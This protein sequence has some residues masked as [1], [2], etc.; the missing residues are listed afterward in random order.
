MALIQDYFLKTENYIKEYGENTLVFIQVGS[1]YEVY[2]KKSQD[3]IIG[4]KIELFALYCDLNIV[5][6]NVCVGEKQIVM[7]GF[8]DFLIDK[9]VK[10]VLDKGFTVIE[11][12]QDAP[13]KNTTRSVRN[14]YS[15]GSYF[16]TQ[17]TENISNHSICIWIYKINKMI[18]IGLVCIDIFTGISSLFEFQ[19]IYYASPTTFDELERYISIYNPSE[20]IFIHNLSSQEI[21]NIIQFIHLK[22]KTNHIISLEDDKESINYKK[23]INC[24]KQI[25]QKEILMKFFPIQDFSSF[26]EPYTHVIFAT[27]AFCF[28]LDFLFLH[29][30]HLVYKIQEP[31]FEN[32]NQRLILANHSLKQLNILEDDN[33]K[34]KYSCMLNL[35]NNCKTNMGKRKFNN[36]FLNPLN[37]VDKLNS[38]YNLLESLLKLNNEEEYS[39]IQLQLTKMKDLEKINRQIL[40]QKIPPKTFYMIYENSFI[41]QEIIEKVEK[42]KILW[43]YLQ[44]LP[45]FHLLKE[46]IVQITDYIKSNLNINIISTCDQYSSFDTNFILQNIDEDLDNETRIIE[47]SYDKLNVCKMY[48]HDLLANYEKSKKETEYIKIH[49]TEKNNYSLSITN[50][51]SKI[52]KDLLKNKKVELS[53]L[54]SY[55]KIQKEFVLDLEKFPLEFHKQTSTNQFIYHVQINELCKNIHYLKNKIKEHIQRVYS[56]FIKKFGPFYKSLECLIHFITQIDILWCHMYNIQKFHLTKPTIESSDQSFFKISNIRHLLIEHFQTEEIYVANDLDLGTSTQQGMLLYGTNAVGKTSLIKSIG[57]AILMAQSGMF[58]PCTNMIYCPYKSIFTRIIG[59][60]NLFKGLS[61]FAVEMSEL[62]TILRMADKNSLILGD[63]LCSGTESVSAI[64]IFLAGIKQ[65]YDKKSSFIFA[66]HYHEII[67]MEEITSLENLS[68]NHMEVFYDKEKE[69][70]IY[71]R[72]VKKGPG[73]NMYGLEVCKSLLLP[74]DFLELANNIRLKYHPES[75][76][77]LLKKTSQYNSQKIKNLCENCGLHPCDEVHHLEHQQTANKKGVIKTD[78]NIFHKNHLANLMNLCKS[79]HDNIHKNKKKIKK[80]KGNIFITS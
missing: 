20:T 15:P 78:Q 65:L 47:E 19:E 61:T 34:G 22:S 37:D 36:I 10:K 56:Q 68:L 58:V 17:N 67:Q 16:F 71:D 53:Y 24:E 70:L 18:Y 9:Y 38:Q 32:N 66:T 13:E 49:E 25:Y 14:I 5:E 80:V 60:D 44:F 54:S 50:R 57:I 74:Q 31:I 73:N 29:N 1:F 11:I 35:L 63:E 51:R 52:L 64:S 69:K 33:C 8:K 55:D 62:R 48:F 39:F 40:L 43:D 7:A 3:K 26:I 46:Y 2:G 6:K 59:N 27:Q 79:C 45:D 30:P 72:K 76:S 12:V 21:Q 42:N 23:V 77:I 28:L 4:S 75:N 41:I